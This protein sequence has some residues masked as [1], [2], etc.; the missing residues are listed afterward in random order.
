MHPSRINHAGIRPDNTPLYIKRGWT[1]KG[2]T[3][4]GY[5]RTRFGA[6]AGTIVR[7]GDLFK[8]LIQDPPMEKIQKHSRRGCFSQEK[9]NTWRINLAVNPK[10][11]DVSAI[12][13]YVEKVIN[14]SFML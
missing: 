9:G 1:L 10:D 12:I 7:Q 8:V 5:Y 6:W 13:Y 2:N 14:E 11:R 4:R 3:Y